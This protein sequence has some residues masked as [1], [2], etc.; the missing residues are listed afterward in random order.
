MTEYID[1]SIICN[2][3]SKDY[4]IL[5]VQRLYD[6][7]FQAGQLALLWSILSRHACYLIDL[8]KVWST[9]KV[10]GCR[11]IGRHRI[12]IC[13]I[14]GSA[15]RCQ[16]F[17]LNFHPLNLH[18][19]HRWLGI[20]LARRRGKKLPPVALIQIRDFYFV[21]DG[22]HRISVAKALGETEVEA[23]VIV[24]DV[25]G[26]LPWEETRRASTPILK[27]LWEVNFG[28]WIGLISRHASRHD[29]G[30]GRC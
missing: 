21:E 27:R 3:F 19:Q 7:I 17:D 20:A 15:G 12:P 9:C 25:V 22:H 28:K 16:D 23:N 2:P 24:W 13:K 6:Q 1:C 18:T 4:T 14:K 5:A 26:T 29:F 8:A 10:C 30:M 11:N